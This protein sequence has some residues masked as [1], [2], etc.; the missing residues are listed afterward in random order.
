MDV[1]SFWAWFILGHCHYAQGRF[2]EAA[3]DFAA[4]AARAPNFAWV[5]FNR[6]LA[7]SRA[8]RLKDAE[9]AYDRALVLDP[10]LAEAAVD[11]ALVELE[12]NHLERAQTDLARAIEL[13]RDD[14]VVLAALAETW[15]RLGRHDEAERYFARLLEGHQ[16]GTVVRVARGITRIRTDPTG[17][18][19]DFKA[20]LEHDPR[21]AQ[22]LYGMALLARRT[23]VHKA[24]EHL[25]RALDANPN[26][27]DAVQLRALDARPAR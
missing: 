20:A 21:N 19:A 14:V 25:D 23:D 5:H 18:E 11:R 8:G 16:S 24:I 26:L 17:A 12:L 4:C 22:A 27:I 15:A 6:G 13:G 3:G 7:L 1:T 2:L 9:D 10:N